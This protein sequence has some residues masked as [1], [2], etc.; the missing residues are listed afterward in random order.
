MY[1][2][3]SYHKWTSWTIISTKSN[4]FHFRYIYGYICDVPTSTTALII[5]IITY[6]ILQI[7]LVSLGLKQHLTILLL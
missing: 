1:D 5:I 7:T 3:I 4:S 6:Y 2:C